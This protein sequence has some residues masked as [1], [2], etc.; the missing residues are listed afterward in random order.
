MLEHLLSG[1]AVAFS[2]AVLP[3]L[4][5]GVLG[6]IILGALPGLTATMGVAILLPFT[7]GMEAT[8]ALVM[9]IGVYIGGIYGGSIAAILLK[10][11]GTPASAASVLDGH[12]M[13][14]RGQAARAL[15]I[16]A[17]ASFVGGLISTIILIAIAPM[18]A[19]FAL[20]FNAPEYFALA[21][22]GLTII[23]SVSSKNILKGLLAGTIG[24]LVSTVGLD[25]ISS[26][27]RF[28]FGN[29]DLYSGFNV[30]PVLIGLFALSEALSQLEKLVGNKHTPPPKFDHKLLSKQDLKDMLPTA[31]KSGLMGTTIGSV[32]GAGADIS[33]FVCYNEA[34]RV[35]ED[36]DE[37]GKGSVRGLAAAEA[38]NNGVTGGSLVPL[39]TLGVPGDAVAAVLLGALIVQGLTPGP[40][41]FAQNPEVVY[42]VFS[43]MLV[44]NVIMLGIGIFGIRF[45]C[46]IIEVPKIIM[47][48]III[49]L[50]VVG[51]FAINNSMF[52]VGIAICFGLLGF[53]LNKIEVP[54]SP[55]LLA[56]IL[57]PMAETNL[58]KALLMYEG[59]WSFLY[60]RPIAL[61]FICLAVFSVYST[62][63]INRRKA[64]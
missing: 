20:R 15:S 27:P 4:I 34:K 59:S 21:L 62:L 10:T 1:L 35:A 53:V 50:S 48:P 11:P 13:A 36:P 57:G 42:G 17:V 64:Q 19:T 9:L 43:S 61:A 23:A 46:R 63:K 18:L 58:R 2:P 7:F 54:S 47:I 26:V 37:F 3:I 38:G 22:F 39:L 45:F 49:F 52:D 32:P 6:G 5:F 8:P 56:I 30:I 55:I 31:I 28:T 16:S 25:P 60:D 24:L 14:V 40:L 12:T 51:A 33:A 41:L 44:A 29:M